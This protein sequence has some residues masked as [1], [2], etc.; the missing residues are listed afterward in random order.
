MY[1]SSTL[2]YMH[3]KVYG[4]RRQWS[5]RLLKYIPCTL[6][7]PKGLGSR[8]AR[9]HHVKPGASCPVVH[10]G[11]EAHEAGEVHRI[12]FFMLNPD[13]SSRLCRPSPY[14]PY[15]VV[16][17]KPYAPCPA[18]PTEDKAHTAGDVPEGSTI[19]AAGQSTRKLLCIFV[20]RSILTA[21]LNL[22][23]PPYATQR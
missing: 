21:V 7:Q 15:R 4:R 10:A 9:G 11:N 12:I 20:K 6:S 18:A 8:Q 2:L 13:A 19:G 23:A 22:S 5:E 17:E 3:C 14:A 16:R 1:A